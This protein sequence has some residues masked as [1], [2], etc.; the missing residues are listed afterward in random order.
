M[1]IKLDNQTVKDDK[2]ELGR[3]IASHRCDVFDMDGNIGMKIPLVCIHL[4][5]DKST[6]VYFCKI[7][8]NRPKLCVDF[9][10]DRATD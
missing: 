8:N 5:F 10:C 9:L 7:Y 3:W 2:S 6:A 1:T 4:D